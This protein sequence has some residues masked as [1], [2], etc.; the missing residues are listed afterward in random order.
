MEACSIQTLSGCD[1]NALEAPSIALFENLTFL[2][3]RPTHRQKGYKKRN[4][5]FLIDAV[6][7]AKTSKETSK[8]TYIEPSIF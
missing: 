8:K 5:N 1:E 4:L 2:G 7:F 6:L 3:R